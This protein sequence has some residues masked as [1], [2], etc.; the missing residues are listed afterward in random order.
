MAWPAEQINAF[1]ILS[2]EMPLLSAMGNSSCWK[3]RPILA[4]SNLCLA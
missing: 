3:V 2:G 1:T 4:Q